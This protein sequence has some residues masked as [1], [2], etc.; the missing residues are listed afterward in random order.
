MTNFIHEFNNRIFLCS[1]SIPPTT[2]VENLLEKQ[3]STNGKICT[4]I[5][6]WGGLVPGN[7]NELKKLLAQGVVGFKC[8]LFPPS[9]EYFKNVTEE[10]VELACKHLKD[11]NALIAVC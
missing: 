5:G 8:F 10:D 1:N 7:V 4:D 6:F 2:T 3:K 11:T 9:D